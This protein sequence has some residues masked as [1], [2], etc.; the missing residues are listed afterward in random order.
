[1]NGNP[2][3]HRN[4]NLVICQ[5]VTYH[6]L[7]HRRATVVRAGGNPDTDKVCPRCHKPKPFSEYY[8]TVS[9]GKPALSSRCIACARE[10]GRQRCAARKK[11]A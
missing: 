10:D 1:M 5:D 4:S 8:Q 3:D 2:R 9:Y 7:L 6:R 11:A